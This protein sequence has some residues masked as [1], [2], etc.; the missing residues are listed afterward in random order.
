MEA[1][2]VIGCLLLS[3]VAIVLALF[4]G[5]WRFEHGNHDDNCLILIGLFA[6]AFLCVGGAVTLWNWSEWKRP[7]RK[8]FL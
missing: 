7:K 8:L 3:V 5:I 6:G 1:L 4:A 2:R